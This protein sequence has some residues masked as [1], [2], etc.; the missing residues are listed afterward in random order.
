MSKRK[1]L[2]LE[3][4]REKMVELLQEAVRCLA[5]PSRLSVFLMQAFE[6]SVLM[7]ASARRAGRELHLGPVFL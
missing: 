2:S 5:L 1:G 3:E 4:K 6:C 7:S